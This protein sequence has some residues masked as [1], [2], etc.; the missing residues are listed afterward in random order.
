[1]EAKLCKDLNLNNLTHN[2]EIPHQI[3]NDKIGLS[4]FM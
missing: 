3:L 4:E 1:M 2:E